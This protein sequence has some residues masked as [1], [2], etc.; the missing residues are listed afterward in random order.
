[1]IYRIESY[2]GDLHRFAF[3]REAAQDIAAH[4]PDG[5]IVLA[6]EFDETGKITR[7]W[8]LHGRV[9]PDGVSDF[10][11]PHKIVSPDL[12]AGQESKPADPTKKGSGPVTDRLLCE[13]RERQI[14]QAAS[15]ERQERFCRTYQEALRNAEEWKVN[16]EHLNS[17]V[18]ERDATIAAYRAKLA[19][20]TARLRS[21]HKQ[22][23]L[24]YRARLWG[25]RWFQ[26]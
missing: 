6:R 24:A 10:T 9:I 13:I 2:A 20:T 11:V 16:V 5:L 26:R 8:F 15:I 23:S 21:V 18:A 4:N 12:Q 22:K 19:E 3:L 17:V 1:M 7:C 25:R 14:H